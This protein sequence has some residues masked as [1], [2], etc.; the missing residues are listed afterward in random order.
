MIEITPAFIKRHPYLL[1]DGRRFA[2]LACAG[3]TIQHAAGEGKQS[4]VGIGQQLCPVVNTFTKEQYSM[5][6]ALH[7]YE[8]GTRERK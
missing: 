2:S 8:Y 1:A 7:A 4:A 6:E 3:H 5:S